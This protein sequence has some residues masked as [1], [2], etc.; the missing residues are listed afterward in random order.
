[1]FNS[2]R[3]AS[4]SRVPC[5]LLS[6][7]PAT[8]PPRK[9]QAWEKQSLPGMKQLLNFVFFYL[10]S[11]LTMFFSSCSEPQRERQE[12]SGPWRHIDVSDSNPSSSMEVSV[13]VPVPGIDQ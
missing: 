6:G 1:M 11:F 10:S 13:A 5:P 9:L 3:K 7:V 8:P 4:P 12:T 2:F